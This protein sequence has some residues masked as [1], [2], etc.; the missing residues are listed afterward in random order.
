MGDIIDFDRFKER[1]DLE[2]FAKKQ[3]EQLIKYRVE[4]DEVKAKLTHAEMLLANMPQAALKVGS[5]EEELCKIE[6]HRLYT[7]AQSGPLEFEQVKIFDIYVKSL[8][9]IKG[10][11]V[12][13]GK[14]RSEKSHLS[15]D[16]LIQLALQATDEST[17]Q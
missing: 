7:L 13:G 6:I 16:Q 11:S 14:S 12:E 8:L 5:K 17:D 1:V 15:Q 3:M 2:Q 4:I 10:K 9:A